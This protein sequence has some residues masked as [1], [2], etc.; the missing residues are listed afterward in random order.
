MSNLFD[1]LDRG[2]PPEEKKTNQPDPAQKL[3]DWLQKWSKPNISLR[4]IQLYAPRIVR[5]HRST[6]DAATEILVKNNWLV[7]DKAHRRDRRVWQIIRR[8]MV[9]P[10]VKL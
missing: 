5:T 8:P 1:R 3:L 6:I 10:T 4:D 9:H 2:R 7:P